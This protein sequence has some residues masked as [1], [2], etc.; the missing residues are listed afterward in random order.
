MKFTEGAF[1]KWGYAL[2]EREFP[3]RTF[4]WSQYNRISATKGKETADE[5]LKRHCL[6]EKP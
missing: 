3:D 6:K 4:S 2:A 5:K 1:M